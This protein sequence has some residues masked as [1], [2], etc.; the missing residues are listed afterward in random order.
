[1]NIVVMNENK[2]VIAFAPSREAA[3]MYG[4][5]HG[6]ST[7]KVMEFSDG[8]ID[9]YLAMEVGDHLDLRTNL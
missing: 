6:L 3:I 8:E 7:I 1:M 9:N 5:D 2:V 4:K